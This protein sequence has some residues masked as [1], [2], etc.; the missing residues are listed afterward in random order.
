MCES[1]WSPAEGMH[2]GC[3]RCLFC[4]INKARVWQHR[5]MCENACWEASVFATLTYDEMMLPD[6]FFKEERGNMVP[7]AE[8]SVNP[9]AV[10]L[11]MKR[12]RRRMEPLEIRYY[13]VGEYGDPN[14]DEIHGQGRPHYH[15][16]LFGV[17]SEFRFCDERKKEVAY[18][19][20]NVVEDSWK[21]GFVHIGEINPRS[22]RYITGYV[23]KHMD[24]HRSKK[25]KGR[26]PEFS[27]MSNRPGLG[28]PYMTFVAEKLLE[29][30]YPK[31][32]LVSELR[33]GCSSL[34]LG[35]YLTSKL[36]EIRGGDVVAEFRESRSRL[37][38]RGIEYVGWCDSGYL[39]R[40]TAGANYACVGNSPDRSDFDSIYHFNLAK[41]K[42]KRF[43]IEGLERVFRKRAR[44]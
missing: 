6:P 28:A 11:F 16:C 17:G 4:R 22:S 20:G 27:V 33:F 32:K 3:G 26:Y 7:Y 18:S 12:L 14:E 15:L 43:R 30:G 8:Y 34:P 38:E 39:E 5:I 21:C 44:L 40:R 35:R 36:H 1:P 42:G 23:T 37:V 13:A 41:S 19:L 29:V 31:E 10:Q 2:V 9:R 24:F 25:L